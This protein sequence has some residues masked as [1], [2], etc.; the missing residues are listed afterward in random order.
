[1]H[2]SLLI[3][4]PK[5]SSRHQY[6][7]KVLFSEIYSIEYSLTENLEDFTQSN[8]AKIN[9]SNSIICE[10]EL[11]IKHNGLLNQKGINQIDLEID[12]INAT[13]CF[14]NR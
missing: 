12:N 11:F 9:Y 5:I 2:Q 1:M 10:D 3:Y 14:F 8:N 13:P 6:I 4:T 7:F